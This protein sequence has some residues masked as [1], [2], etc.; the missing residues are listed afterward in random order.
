MADFFQPAPGLL[1]PWVSVCHVV[2]WK[3][4][5]LFSVRS[6]SAQPPVGPESQ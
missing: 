2:C 6:I 1:L 4:W 3:Q 5:P